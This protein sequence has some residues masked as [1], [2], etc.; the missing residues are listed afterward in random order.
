MTG[1]NYVVGGGNTT[2]ATEI[3]QTIEQTAQNA[4]QMGENATSTAQNEP[5]TVD[6]NEHLLSVIN[7]QKKLI[8]TYE[9]RI[10]LLEE[11]NR[12]LKEGGL[13]KIDVETL[14][15]FKAFLQ[16]EQGKEVSNG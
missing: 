8:D 1:Q 7:T 12:L 13:L 6:R 2:P 4:P 5:E 15:R 3:N 9:H 16:S 11:Q 10:D 14:E